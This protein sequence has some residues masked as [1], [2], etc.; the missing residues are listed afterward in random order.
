VLERLLEN[1]LDS[2]NERAYQPVFCQLLLAEGYR[3]LHSTRHAPIEFGKD[4]I[5]V[6]RDGELSAFQLKGNPSG[7]LTHAQF[8]E[9]QHQLWELFHQAVVLPGAPPERHRSYLVTN[10][11]VDEEVHRAISDFNL[12]YAKASGAVPLEI[13]SRG[14][15]LELLKKHAEQLWPWRLEDVGLLLELMTHSGRDQ[16]P[17]EKMDAL[18]SLRLG[19][20]E[21]KPPSSAN[22]VRRIASAALLSAAALKPFAVAEN[23]VSIVSG[24]TM[25]IGYAMAAAERSSVRQADVEDVIATVR[26]AIS[27][28][29][30]AL[31]DEAKNR[32][33][34]IEGEPLTDG[35][36]YDGRKV[37]VAGF[38]ALAWLW[39]NREPGLIDEEILANALTLTR[40]IGTGLV[41]WGEAAVPYFLAVCW[42]IDATTGDQKGELSLARLLELILVRNAPR[43][44]IPLPSPYYSFEQV[45]RHDLRKL[46]RGADPL[47]GDEFSGTSWYAE[48]LFSLVVRTNRKVM[49]ADLWP[50]LTR[51]SL[52]SF[53]PDEPWQFCV[54]R[55]D[56]GHEVS[57]HLPFARTWS[58]AV[59]GAQDDRLLNVPKRFAQHPELVL[60]WVML[61][62]HRG[63]PDVIRWLGRQFSKS[64]Y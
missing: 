40:E 35:F 30:A 55:S 21:E 34:L 48:G 22:A 36:V 63:T 49:C 13:W 39:W 52:S 24:W 19:L 54:W 2:V 6:R 16:L 26:D 38:A 18:L 43:S 47:D 31:V 45:R 37:Q 27:R 61:C 41:L 56:H 42:C 64:W 7:R 29:L 5:A 8:R 59:T 53:V 1:W 33:D 10:G 57:R 58:E 15:L 51:M 50:A 4:V 20:L 62:P 17:M 46:L 9:I 25:F 3:V 14:T 32:P 12:Q 11:E 28:E 44:N 23:H 60:L